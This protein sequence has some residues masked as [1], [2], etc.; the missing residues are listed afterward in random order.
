MPRK[1][2][3]SL[4]RDITP[5]R[6]YNSVLVQKLIN[7]LMKDGKKLKS[8]ALVYSAMELAAQKL[9]S[10]D[11]LQTLEDAI[12]N[13]RPH[14]EVKS[15][16]VGGANY[17]VPVP[18]SGERRQVLAMR[19]IRDSCRNKKGKAMSEKLADELLD[20]SNKI[21]AAMKKRDE[22]HRMAEANKAFAHF[23]YR[24]LRLLC[25]FMNEKKEEF[26]FFLLSFH[27]VI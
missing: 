11:P 15:R 4:K 5:D 3:K 13:I 23:A 8:E 19:W 6:K 12:K 20:A 10:E 25:L 2:T 1:K 16:R 26:L 22:T 24:A 18:V 17:Q 27:K 7:K 21:G 9:K 14:M